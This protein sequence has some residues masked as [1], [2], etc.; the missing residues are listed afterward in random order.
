MAEK[1]VNSFRAGQRYRCS[2]TN[3]IYTIEKRPTNLGPRYLLVSLLTGS[4]GL[5]KSA[6]FLN[7]QIEDGELVRED[8]PL[9][10]LLAELN[11]D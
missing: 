4:L 7:I 2:V 10:E 6:A 9:R 8:A 3:K 11:R 5:F 1:A